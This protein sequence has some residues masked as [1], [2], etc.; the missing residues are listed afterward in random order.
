MCEMRVGEIEL[1]EDRAVEEVYSK[2]SP[3]PWDLWRNR[4]NQHKVQISSTILLSY[5]T[6]V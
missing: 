6:V 1:Q 3:D 2:A 5:C 4:D